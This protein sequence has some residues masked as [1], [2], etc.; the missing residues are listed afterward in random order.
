MKQD[1]LTNV[2]LIGVGNLG[3]CFIELQFVHQS[4]NMRISASFEY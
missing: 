1:R 4:N 2:A 3:T